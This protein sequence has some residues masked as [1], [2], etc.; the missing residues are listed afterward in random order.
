[1]KKY[2]SYFLL[3]IIIAACSKD[4]PKKFS[5]M[6]ETPQ[7]GDEITIQFISDQE[8]LK[9]VSE[10]NMII[11]SFGNELL[12]T[13]KI[14]L[15]KKDNVWIGKFKAD[16]DT[17]GLITKFMSSE[18]IDDNNQLG[19]GIPLF[20]NDENELPGYK[21][22]LANVYQRWAGAVSLKKD[23]ELA[24]KYF[25]EDFA[26]HPEIKNEFLNGYVSSFP[27]NKIDSV[28][29]AEIEKLEEKNIFTQSELEFLTNWTRNIGDHVKSLK[30]YELVQEKYPESNLIKSKYY[31]KFRNMLTVEKKLEVFNEYIN[32]DKKSEV[33]AYMLANIVHQQVKEKDIAAAKKLLREYLYLANSNLYNG[34]AWNF[35]ETKKN[36]EDGLKYCE[37]GIELARNEVTKPSG[38]KPVYIDD[39]QWKESRKTSLGVILD[40]YANIQNEL[41]KK[42]EALNSFEEA[43]ILTNGDYPE[44]NESYV[45][46]LFELNQ[47]EKAK[48]KAEEFISKGKSTNKIEEIFNNAFLTLGGSKEELNKQLGKID[49][50]TNQ[51]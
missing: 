4:E 27:K 23:S 8:N 19:Y 38:I 25:K 37:K 10:M 13:S 32:F 17:K 31:G 18:I 43:T 9:E 44:M 33:S 40:T 51:N 6:P 28:A 30:Y 2:F 42:K 21:A 15:K 1:M 41:G 7:V 39:E 45:S 20:D 35:F 49:E 5:F 14:V 26:K 47:I 3:L 12:N 11:Y 34:I 29:A 16:K 36:L 22:G 50:S 46:L 48:I 24:N